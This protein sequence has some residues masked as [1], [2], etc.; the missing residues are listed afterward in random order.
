[1]GRT[2]KGSIYAA[3]LIENSRADGKISFDVSKSIQV[4]IKEKPQESQ[5]K[6]FVFWNRSRQV[7]WLK[8]IYIR[9]S[10]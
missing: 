7:E 6:L 5:L 9:L 4:L 2:K 3:S 1:M 8:P 10:E